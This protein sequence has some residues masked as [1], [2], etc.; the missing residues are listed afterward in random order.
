[1]N[2]WIGY[3]VLVLIFG[4]GFLFLNVA[5]S[6]FS[7]L[8]LTAIRLIVATTILNIVLLLSGGRLPWHWP[9]IRALGL[10]GIINY[11]IPFTLLAWAQQQGVDSGLTGVLTALNPL[12]TLILAHY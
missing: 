1:M 12:F 5:S 11:S 2:K 4:S 9:Q 3:W 10:L 6:G 8:E 7:A